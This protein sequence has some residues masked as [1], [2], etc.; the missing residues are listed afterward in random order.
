MRLYTSDA[1]QRQMV[2]D[3]NGGFVLNQRDVTFKDQFRR[4]SYLS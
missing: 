1:E 4:G 2:V 3:E